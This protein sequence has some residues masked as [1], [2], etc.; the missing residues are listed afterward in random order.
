VQVGGWLLAEK[1]VEGSGRE[2]RSCRVSG[3]RAV[4]ARSAQICAV[5]SVV[6][7]K[8]SRVMLRPRGEPWRVPRPGVAA[9]VV[10]RNAGKP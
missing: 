2:G 4:N 8:V 7:A 9:E 6:F 3:L 1:G 5:R 10:R